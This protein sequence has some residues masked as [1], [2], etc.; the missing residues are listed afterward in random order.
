MRVL[1]LALCIGCVGSGSYLEQSQRDRV[2]E[3]FVDEATKDSTL[4]KFRERLR[5]A[6]QAKDVRQLVP[7]FA[8]DVVV[9][10]DVRGVEALLRHYEFADRQSSYWRELETILSLGGRFQSNGTF[11]APY[12]SCPYPPRF[13][14]DHVVVLEEKLPAFAKPSEKSEV[15]E[16]L[17]C[18]VLRAGGDG[19]PQVPA[20]SGS[21]FPVW[22]PSNRWAFVDGTKVRSPAELA[23]VFQQRAGQ[24]LI[25]MFTAPD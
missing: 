2:R 8:N 5:A 16:W 6:V 4:L 14:H 15:L 21:W 3:C 23:L 13:G 10:Q 18:D 11:C 25:V 22:L 7:L 12:L 20:S 19:L 9:E 1:L 17:S 24:W